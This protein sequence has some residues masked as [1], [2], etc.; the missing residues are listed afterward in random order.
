VTAA[1]LSLAGC[2]DLDV[3]NPPPDGGPGPQLTV[4]KP[5]PGDTISLATPVEI[6]AVSVH[7]VASVA[8]TCGATPGTGVFTWT[9]SPYTGLVD[10]TRCTL[11]TINDGGTGFGSLPLSFIGI[12]RLGQTSSTSFTVLLD[13]TTAALTA[14]LPDRVLPRA[15]FE[16]TVVSDRPLLLPP[17]V[18][19]AGTEANRIA[20]LQGGDGGQIYQVGF[21]TTP[22]LGIDLYQ[23]DPFAPPIETLLDTEKSVSLTVDARA[24]N[25]NP[26]HIEQ[27]VLL[28]RVL[29]DRVVPGR[30]A[31]QAS[32]PVASDAGVQLALATVDTNPDGNSAW[33][34][35]LFRPGNG[36]FVPFDPAVVQVGGASGGFSLDA[37]WNAQGLD[38]LG[39][40]LFVRP[41]GNGSEVLFVDPPAEGSSIR[42]ANG[43]TTS[44]TVPRPLT[45]VDDLLC[46][47]DVVQGQPSTFTC[48]L[49]ATQTVSCLSAGQGVLFTTGSAATI[50]AP[51]AG[52]VAGTNGPARAYLAPNDQAS[53]GQAWTVGTIGTGTFTFQAPLDPNATARGCNFQKVL[54]LLPVSDGTFVLQM[55]SLCLNGSTPDFPILRVDA[56]GTIKGAY[57]Q[58]LGAPAPTQWQVL[59]ALPDGSIVTMRNQ[60][61]LTAF[62]RWTMGATT[63]A[64]TAF[65]PGF[66]VYQPLDARLPDGV[67]ASADGTLSVVLNSSTLGDVVVNF[68]PPLKPTWIYRYN[69]IANASTLAADD[70]H[71]QVYYVDPLNNDVVAIKPAVA[72][73]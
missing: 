17:T 8:V 53:C 56:S 38:S 29:W 66:F 31:L 67:V 40:T 32:R 43:Y 20:Q 34:P 59:T 27:A 39:R 51:R 50:G 1:C 14:N 44:L 13:T 62:E 68:S 21:T 12:D 19:L 47:P 52:G 72:G 6:Q 7:G 5:R 64:A 24:L 18:R 45:R 48:L 41:A 69:R 65:V 15:P 63:A 55:S 22:G 30:V 10:F 46:T 37:G 49:T 73:N 58:P 26:A 36:T 28:S 70:A 33:L 9:V 4:V 25:D 11:A 61:P 71:G 16:V 3:P 23:G 57:I 2:Y 42:P 35:G 60:P 54:R